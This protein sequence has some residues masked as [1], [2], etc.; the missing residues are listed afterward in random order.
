[1]GS[2]RRVLSRRALLAA[3]LLLVAANLRPAVASVGP[4]LADV[5]EDLGLSSAGVALLTALPVL[6]FGAL[7]PI[8]PRLGRRHGLEP[9]LGAVLVALAAGLLLR[10]GAGP[11]G[12]FAGTAL[13]AGAIAVGNVLVPALVKRDFAD[14]TGPLMGAYTTAIA[15]SAAVAAGLTVPV[16]ELVGQ[17]WRGALGV[18]A[19]PALVALVVWLPYVREHSRPPET[20]AAGAVRAL[21][22]EPLAWQVT[23]FFGLQSL[24]FYSVLAWLPTIYQDEGWT[25]AA[26]GLLLSVS[27]LVQ[28]PVSLAVPV[29][30]SRARD[31]RALAAAASLLTAAGLAG[32]L[33]APT[34]AAYLWVGLLGLGQGA[35]F[36]L[37]LTLFVLRGGT[38]ADTA[39]LS[40][41]AQTV[42]YL[43][44]A[45]GPLAVGL[46]HDA[47]GG[48]D[49]PLALLLGLA[50]VQV[51]AGD[52]ASRA[53]TI[54]T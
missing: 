50:L 37:V 54:R 15:G 7:A 25:P 38:T 42:G 52:L 49:L 3:A 29:L 22:R 4:V 45:A 13:A 47:R 10:L 51:V 24:L 8:A 19:V 5:R 1:V 30:A 32:V 46:L 26:S 34:A 23:A 9:V 40:A 28:M 31:Q 6:C 41:L 39:R 2:S 48:W 12:L 33:V 44:A 16:G 36:A 18:W 35:A 11:A 43:V 14:R 17:G 20:V 53:R 27:V 21:L